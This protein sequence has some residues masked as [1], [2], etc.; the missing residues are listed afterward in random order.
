MTNGITICYEAIQK[1]LYILE[2]ELWRLHHELQ[3][4]TA[5]C[6]YLTPMPPVEPVEAAI[7]MAQDRV[8]QLRAALRDAEK[9]TS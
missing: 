1:R 8:G 6:V 4:V 9:E 2:M 3:E 7:L 5:P